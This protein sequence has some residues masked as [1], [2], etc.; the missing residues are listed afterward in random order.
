[1]RGDK[2]ASVESL[3]HFDQRPPGARVQIAEGFIE[4]EDQRVTGEH[5]G[6]ANAFPFAQ[7][8]LQRA[9]PLVSFQSA[10][11]ARLSAIAPLDVLPRQTQV[12][13]AEGDV[14]ANRGTK[15]LVIRILEQ[16]SDQPADFRQVFA[17][18]EKPA[19]WTAAP[20]DEGTACTA[21]AAATGR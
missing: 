3:E 14:F 4:G 11:A 21:C 8:Q 13:R 7:A 9:P 12:E 15:E 10:R 5:A 17:R 20:L 16:E 1:M 6:Q 19:T 2:L 18:R